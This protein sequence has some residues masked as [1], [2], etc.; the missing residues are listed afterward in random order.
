MFIVKR[1]KKG[2]HTG[3]FELTIRSS[4]WG[5]DESNT[6]VRSLDFIQTAAQRQSFRL[7]DF[8][9]AVA[10]DEDS[11]GALNLVYAVRMSELG[12]EV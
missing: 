7:Y 5:R 4:G 8:R 1:I 11:E 12:L 9:Q 3:E 10:M 6:V 2:V